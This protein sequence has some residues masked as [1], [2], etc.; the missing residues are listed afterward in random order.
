MSDYEIKPEHFAVDETQL[1]E[2][3]IEHPS[4][5]YYYASLAADA[6]MRLDE[7]RRKDDVLRADLSLGVRKSPEDFGL[8]KT[9]EG[10]IEAFIESDEQVKISAKKIIRLKNELDLAKAAVSAL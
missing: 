5:V 3:W 8:K 6:Q 7:A 9:T 10:L 1:V 2:E 4:R